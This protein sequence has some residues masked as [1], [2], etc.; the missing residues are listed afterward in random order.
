MLNKATVTGLLSLN[1]QVLEALYETL[2]IPRAILRLEAW[3]YVC[4]RLLVKQS[5]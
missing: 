1:A 5:S 4:Y 2:F 3:I